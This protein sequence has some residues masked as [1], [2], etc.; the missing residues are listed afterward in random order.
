MDSRKVPKNLVF[1]PRKDAFLMGTVESVSYLTKKCFIRLLNGLLV[2]CLFNPSTHTPVVGNSATVGKIKGTVSDYALLSISKKEIPTKFICTTVT[3]TAQS[4]WQNPNRPTVDAALPCQAASYSTS[5][6]CT[7]LA[8]YLFSLENW[9]TALH[10]CINQTDDAGLFVSSFHQ[11]L[12]DTAF[13][14]SAAALITLNFG[15]AF[16]TVY[17]TYECFSV[18][19]K[20]S[21]E[22]P[23]FFA[24]TCEDDLKQAFML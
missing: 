3:D 8:A 23:I 15:C 17:S 19:K 16:Q 22:F 9:Q 21:D 7:D 18:I 1:A 10:V 6:F 5:D 24:D 20:F 2:S 13:F 14:V 12:P 4:T 11:A